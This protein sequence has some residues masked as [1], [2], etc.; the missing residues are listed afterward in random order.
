MVPL[1]AAALSQELLTLCSPGRTETLLCPPSDEPP[2]L[3]LS[4]VVSA[5]TS[6]QT[7]AG[8]GLPRHRYLESEELCESCTKSTLKSLIRWEGANIKTLDEIEIG[9]LA[10][11][12]R[13]TQYLICSTIYRIIKVETPLSKF[14]TFYQSNKPLVA[15]QSR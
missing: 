10:Q 2:T 11:L 5:S 12:R 7:G 3:Q 6:H 13:R 8:Y 1:L 14:R 15:Q 9:T 4:S